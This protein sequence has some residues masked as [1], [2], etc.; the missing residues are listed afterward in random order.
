MGTK[1]QNIEQCETLTREL[2][3]S[4]YKIPRQ[5]QRSVKR[6]GQV[7]ILPMLAREGGCSGEFQGRYSAHVGREGGCSGGLQV[8]IL[9]MLAVEGGC[10]CG[11]QVVILPMLAGEGAVVVAVVVDCR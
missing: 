11:L 2:A 3:I 9:P 1:I 7:V 5:R 10:S 6:G 8:V 4:A